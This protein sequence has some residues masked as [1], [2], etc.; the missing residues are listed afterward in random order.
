MFL[1]FMILSFKHVLVIILEV[2]LGTEVHK[3]KANGPQFVHLSKTATASLQIC[4]ATLPQQLRRKF[5][6]VIKMSKL[7]LGSTFEQSW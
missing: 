6:S 2:S 5:D 7:I 1:R 4:P 3:R